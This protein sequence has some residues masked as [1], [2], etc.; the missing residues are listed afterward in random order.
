[1][2]RFYIFL[3]ALVFSVVA[4][5]TPSDTENNEASEDEQT[6]ENTTTSTDEASG[7]ESE[8]GYEV[9]VLTADLPSPRKEMKALVK[10]LRK[11]Y[12]NL[13]IVF[14]SAKPSISRW[15]LKE[16]YLDFNRTLKKYANRKKNIDFVDVWFPM[17][18]E[19]GS[20]NKSLFIEDDLHMNPAGYEIWTKVV[21]DYLEK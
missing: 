7:S 18:N 19:D 6:E 13:P 14:I 16:Q 8:L 11:T 21:N 15:E 20:L 17:M 10:V 4:C 2:S 12:K 1:M 3:F 9:V 5:N